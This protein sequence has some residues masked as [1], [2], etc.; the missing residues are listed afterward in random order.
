MKFPVKFIKFAF[1]GALGTVTNLVLF[2]LLA[3]LAKF[4]DIPV[5]IACFL[6]AA[7]QNYFINAL[8]TFKGQLTQKISLLQWYKFIISS[9]AGYAVNLVIYILLTRV[10]LWSY[11]VIPQGIGILSGMILN[12]LFS[13]FFV[14]KN[15]NN[16]KDNE[17]ESI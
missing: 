13:S 11:K 14:F 3:D 1:T 16:S 2:F 5:N 7:T 10:I 17:Q 8:W 9:L 4:P 15:K 6:L 12:Y